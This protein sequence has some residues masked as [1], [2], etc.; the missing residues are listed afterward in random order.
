MQTDAKD[1]EQTFGRVFKAL[2]TKEQRKALRSAVRREA[3]RVRKAAAVKMGASGLGRGT[4]TPLQK[5]IYARVYPDRFGLGFIVSVVPHGRRGIH[6]NRQGK[7]KPVALFADM[8]TVMRRVG[9]RKKGR[10]YISKLTGTKQR[11]YQRS[12]HSTGRMRASHFMSDAEKQS[13]TTVESTLY[14][15]LTDS[16]TRAAKRQGLL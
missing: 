14:Q 6:T 4:R 9:K 11:A 1:I 15:S 7:E 8:G 5:S 13:I 3:N 2:D 10:S 16:V 12:G